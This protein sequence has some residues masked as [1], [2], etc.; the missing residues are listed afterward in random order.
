MY[1][2]RIARWLT[3]DTK[4][5][6]ASPYVGLRA[7]PVNGVDKDGGETDNE[8]EVTTVNNK[9]TRIVQTGNKGGNVTDYI[10]YGNFITMNS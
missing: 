1:D 3:V 6:Y 4:G 2:S 9:I 8:Y 5:Q 7:D 10:T